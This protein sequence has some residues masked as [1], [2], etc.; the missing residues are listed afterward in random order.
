MSTYFGKPC[1]YG[2]SG[3]RRKSNNVCVECSRNYSKKQSQENP[4][5]HRE[6]SKK[7]YWKNREKLLPENTE[8]AKRWY[9]EN[10]ER[11]L[12]TRKQWRDKNKKV[13]KSLTAKYRASKK[14]ATP[15]WADQELINL[16]YEECP[17]GYEVDH[18]IPLSSNS[19][20]GLHCPDNFQYLTSSQN[21]QKSNSFGKY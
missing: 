2:H 17:E 1:K 10:T 19:V 4:E 11:A 16:I 14:K 15:T 9:K 20:C 6:N 7:Y 12:Q 5:K 8:R 13:K 21:K 18:I 3:E